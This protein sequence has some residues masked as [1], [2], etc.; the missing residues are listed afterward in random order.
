MRVLSFGPGFFVTLGNK[1]AYYAV[2]AHFLCSVVT[3]VTFS[4]F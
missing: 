1:R 3:L 2:L 4:N